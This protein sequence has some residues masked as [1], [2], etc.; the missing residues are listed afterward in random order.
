[1]PIRYRDGYLY[2]LAEDYSI[3]LVTQPETDVSDDFIRFDTNGKWTIL[4]GYEW[5]GPSGQTFDTKDFMR[6]SLVHD[7]LYQLI[8]RGLIKDCRAEADDILR[9]I[10]LQDGM[11]QARAEMVHNAVR[12]FGASAAE[13][14]K[15]ILTAP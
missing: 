9:M 5:D 12:A 7:V 6:G 13:N 2:Q 11:S 1:M 8:R 15:P 10:C 3:D 4:K 14:A